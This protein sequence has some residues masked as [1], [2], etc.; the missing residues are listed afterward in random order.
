MSDPDLVTIGEVIAAAEKNTSPEHWTWVTNGVGEGL[1]VVRNVEA[2]N[3]LALVPRVMRS[4]VDIDTSASFVGVPLEF[5]L[6]L[7]PVGALALFDE[8]DA[9]AAGRAA[10]ATGAGMMCSTLTHRPWE[11]VAATSPGKVMFQLYVFGNR[12]WTGHVLDRVEGAGFAAMAV[13]VDTPVVARRD[14]SLEQGYVWSYPEDGPP[15][16]SELGW[17]PAYRT[18]YTVDDFAWLCERASI[19]IVAKGIMSA[20]DARIAVDA[21]AS[22]IYVSNHGGR[23]VDREIS[24][25]EM[26]PEIVAAVGDEVDI[27]IDSGF[28]RGAE[29]VAALALGARAVGI[30]RLLCWAL[31]AGGEPALVRTLEILRAEITTTLQNIGCR[32]LADLTPDHVRRSFPVTRPTG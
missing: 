12:E 29:V 15:N 17:D 24:S 31:A 26:L 11:D 30:G 3:R 10:V 13:T 4:V 19:P 28:T 8:G 18:R 6:F 22:G 16:L 1:T 32:S 20:E 5:P 2:L 23:Q 7:A 9:V 27:V 14:P 21:G 25:I